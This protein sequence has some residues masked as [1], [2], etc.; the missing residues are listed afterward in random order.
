MLCVS[1]GACADGSPTHRTIPS[2]LGYDISFDACN[3]DNDGYSDSGTPQYSTWDWPYT[4]GTVAFR[5][6]VDARAPMVYSVFATIAAMVAKELTGIL[7]VIAMPRDAYADILDVAAD[8]IITALYLIYRVILDC[9]RPIGL[10]AAIVDPT[11]KHTK[12]LIPMEHFIPK[13]TMLW[14][15][16]VVVEVL[17]SLVLVA[18]AFYQIVVF[19]GYIADHVQ[20]PYE[21]AYSAHRHCI[22]CST[23]E[24][25]FN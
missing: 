1:T 23:S 4:I 17:S 22:C 16:L 8:S 12:P 6:F 7:I 15:V 19:R 3:P 9:I 10:R 25:N 20:Q 24:L 18:T 14:K 2:F 11:G 21:G 5:C 13:L